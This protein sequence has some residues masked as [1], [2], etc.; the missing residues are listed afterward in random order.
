MIPN[1]CIHSYNNFLGF[2]TEWAK[3]MKIEKKKD[4]FKPSQ[5]LVANMGIS[6]RMAKMLYSSQSSNLVNLW[7][8]AR[9]RA[10][11]LLTNKVFFLKTIV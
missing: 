2:C 6:F 3:P 9:N 11:L 4:P 7:N 1:R 8:Q 10:F 5:Y